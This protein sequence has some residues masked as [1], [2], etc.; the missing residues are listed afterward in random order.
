[1]EQVKKKLIIFGAGK[2]ADAVSYYFNRDSNYSIEAYIIDD[3]FK[4][5]N[6]FLEKPL[7]VL[8]EVLKKYPP[9]NYEVFVAVGYQGLNTFRESKYLY[10]K[11]KGYKIARY[12]SPNV[13]GDFVIGE[14]SIIMDGVTIQP[15]VTIGDN[16]F[17]WGGAML[18]HHATIKNHCWITGGCLIGGSVTIG[19]KSFLGI[20]TIITQEIAIGS[21]CV[22]GAATYITS[23]MEDETVL[24]SN[25]TDKFRLN[26]KQFVK[27]SS[28]FK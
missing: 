16:S 21:S 11:E 24:I 9:Q 26:S 12:I 14:N 8:S 17:L 10:F 13:N 28:F 6:T 20:G 18:G 4:T 23:N 19:E 15:K 27:M 25:P 22:L 1:M 2:I 5:S 7:I 3:D